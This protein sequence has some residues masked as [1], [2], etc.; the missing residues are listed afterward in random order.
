MT[1]LILVD[2]NSLG[3]AGMNSP[4]LTAGEKHTNGTF[5]FIRSIRKIFLDNPDALI[6]VL[7][8]GRSWRKDIWSDYKGKR[9]DTVEKVEEREEY[10]KQKTEML[11]ALE[12]LGVTQCFA[13]NM[14]ADDLAEIYSRT[15]QGEKVTLITGDGD[16][17]QLVNERTRWYD[18]IRDR[19]C[20]NANFESTT[21]F[22]DKQQFVEAKAILGDKDEVPGIKGIGPKYLERMYQIWNSFYEFIEDSDAEEKWQ[23]E[24]GHGLPK[25]LKEIHWKP[26]KTVDEMDL[27]LALGDLATSRRPEP[28]NLRRWNEPLHEENFKQLCYRNAFMSF[29]RDF[30]KFIR[31]FKENRFVRN[32]ETIRT[33]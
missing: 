29:T 25:V 18:P 7:W 3:F 22:K 10:F 13:S 6:M 17:L 31:P 5:T 14:E 2:G 21:K 24:H 33:S 28:K 1:H 23:D 26:S 20:T 32:Q 19:Q 12:L 30:D 27:N 4:R 11:E 15:W 8:D 9:E 16:W